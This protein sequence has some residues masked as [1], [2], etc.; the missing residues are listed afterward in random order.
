MQR[1]LSQ[2]VEW[3]ISEK[4]MVR[5]IVLK[6]RQPGISTWIQGRFYWRTSQ[7]RGLRAYILT[8]RDDATQNLFDI[9]KRFHDRSPDWMKPGLDRSNRKELLFHGRDSSYRV[10]TANSPDA[11][12]SDTIQLFHGSEVAF[13][14]N[15][16]KILTGALQALPDEEL[17]EAYLESTANG[18]GNEYH[19]LWDRAVR[20]RRGD[21]DPDT[22][23]PYVSPWEPIFL[24]WFW[25]GAYA[26]PVPERF[27]PDAREKR[28]IKLHGVTPAQL[29]WRRAK[30]AELGGGKEGLLRFHQEYPA[31]AREAFLSTG[32]RVFSAQRIQ[33]MDSVTRPPEEVGVLVQVGESVEFTPDEE[34]WLEVWERPEE[35][36]HYTAGADVADGE[37]EGAQHSLNVLSRTPRPRQVAR[38]AKECDVDEYG[39]RAVL[40]ALWYNNAWLGIE[41]NGLGIGAVVA[42]R[43]TGY[44]YLYRSTSTQDATIGRTSRTKKVGWLTNQASRDVLISDLVADVRSG[45]LVLYSAVTLDQFDTFVLRQGRAEA[46]EGK[47]D[48]EVMSVG[49]ARQLIKLTSP[50]LADWH[51]DEEEEPDVWDGG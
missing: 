28:L 15:G 36:L 50:V 35:D 12:R 31:T 49:I 17:T 7:L 38:T 40:V 2:E 16:Q 13:W 8:H 1:F 21:T 32:N 33:A 19:R 14:R 5:F 11:G 43:K 26:S 51:D 3:A 48:D 6:L 27:K 4:G 46:E 22:K 20:A 42:A 24:P 47:L 34:G 9:A 30:I 25:H 41:R 45:S 10:A 29:E 18:R 23:R 37:R 44:R 39:R